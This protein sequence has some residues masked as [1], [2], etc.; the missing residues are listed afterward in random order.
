MKNRKSEPHYLEQKQ[1]HLEQ[2]TKPHYVTILAN[3]AIQ[4]NML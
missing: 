1:T 2:K 3:I 4:N